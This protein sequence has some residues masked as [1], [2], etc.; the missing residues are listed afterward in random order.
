M[1]GFHGPSGAGVDY[2]LERSHGK[3]RQ[4]GSIGAACPAQVAIH[5]D[6]GHDIPGACTEPHPAERCVEQHSDERERMRVT[7][8]DPQ[9]GVSRTIDHVG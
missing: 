2:V 3:P 6:P 7:G 1:E 9:D 8:D 5:P 4:A